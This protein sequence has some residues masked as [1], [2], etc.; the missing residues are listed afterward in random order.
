MQRDPEGTETSHLRNITQFAN[1]RVLE[2]GC[3]NGR[4]TWRYA[5][6]ANRVAGID[7]DMSRLITAI[8]DCPPG[9]R[10]TVSFARA[11]SEALPFARGIFDLAVLAWSL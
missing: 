4:L 10:S 8:G 5:G 1:A 11:K 3:G 7:P 9:L 2:I 6:L